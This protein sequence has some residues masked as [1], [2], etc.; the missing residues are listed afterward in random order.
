MVKK[1]IIAATLASI[2]L[3]TAVS[4]HASKRSPVELQVVK[5]VRGQMQQAMDVDP[6]LNIKYGFL[7]YL[8]YEQ[9]ITIKD[10]VITSSNEKEPF[11]VV[12]DE[13]QATHIPQSDKEQDIIAIP[14]KG[15]LSFNGMHIDVDYIA[16]ALAQSDEQSVSKKEIEQATTMMNYFKGDDQYLSSN[17]LL[18]YKK[19]DGNDLNT[20]M[21]LS[22]ENLGHMN[23]SATVAGAYM[24]NGKS[25][26]DNQLMMKLMGVLGVNDLSMKAATSDFLDM[27]EYIYTNSQDPNGD[28]YDM[29]DAMAHLQTQIDQ[30]TR[31]DTLSLSERY[32]LDAMESVKIAVTQDKEVTI[33]VSATNLNFATLMG[34]M[35]QETIEDKE[36]YL[37]DV[38][39]FKLD[40]STL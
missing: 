23:L 27:V 15:I 2:C 12:F 24:L 17:Y 3:T 22:V 37:S 32:I 25:V 21:T 36:Q 10:L 30:F 38:F 26:N 14:E 33:D 35:S 20:N 5:D 34:F 16:N 8:T 7:G 1:S 39:S 13:V 40:F 19:G 4:A 18:D 9:L 28:A 6:D 29:K 31:K 11:R